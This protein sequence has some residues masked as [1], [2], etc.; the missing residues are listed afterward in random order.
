LRRFA[1]SRFFMAC[2]QLDTFSTHPLLLYGTCGGTPD[3]CD[4]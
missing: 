1:V 3:S 4:G 2:T